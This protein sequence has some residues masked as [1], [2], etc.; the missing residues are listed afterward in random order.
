[1]KHSVPSSTLDY[2]PESDVEAYIKSNQTIEYAHTL[3]D[4]IQGQ[5][6]AGFVLNGFYE[7]DFGGTRILDNHIKT[8]LA[9]RVVKA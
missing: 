4:Q 5:I 6:D 2:M 9:T 7:D 1:M 8:F 3:E